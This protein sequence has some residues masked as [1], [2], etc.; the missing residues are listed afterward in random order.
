MLR[1]INTLLLIFALLLTFTVSPLALADT[2]ITLRSIKLNNGSN[3]YLEVGDIKTLPVTFTP[4]NA[5]NT[6]ITFST[7]DK[8]IVSID[9]AGT[10]KALK[11]GRVTLTAEMDGKKSSINATVYTNNNLK[12]TFTE[13]EVVKENHLN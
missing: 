2:N 4:E 1:K 5:I 8:S 12:A 11:T 10:A 13:S 9:K 7:S 6:G 3:I